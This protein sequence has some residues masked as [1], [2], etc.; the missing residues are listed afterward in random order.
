MRRGD[1]TGGSFAFRLMPA[2]ESWNFQ[3]DPPVREVLDMRVSEISIVTFP[4]YTDTDVAVAQRA[5]A[6]ARPGSSIA[7]LRARL[8]ATLGRGT[9]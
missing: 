3:S 1:V 7:L 6:T 9:R 2:G 4:A 8:E 5:L